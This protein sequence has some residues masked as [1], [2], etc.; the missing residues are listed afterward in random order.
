MFL[1]V[2]KTKTHGCNLCGLTLEE[3]KL[4]WILVPG[5]SDPHTKLQRQ[6]K[7]QR[8]VSKALPTNRWWA[9]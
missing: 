2:T 5:P 3:Y 9:E 6:H 4:I 8:N 1:K 7:P